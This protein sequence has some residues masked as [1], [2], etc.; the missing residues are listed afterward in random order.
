MKK[1]FQFSE[2]TPYLLE[3]PLYALL[4]V[5]YFFLVLHLLFGRLKVLFDNHR[6]YYAFAALGLIAIQ[7]IVLDLLTSLLLKFIRP[8]L[9]GGP[10]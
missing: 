8:H 1:K 2:L 4:V 3:I 6:V 9:K 7:G 5:G 10:Q